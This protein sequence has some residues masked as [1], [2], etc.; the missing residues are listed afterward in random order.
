[1]VLIPE[2]CDFR[3]DMPICL[4]ACGSECTYFDFF[5]VDSVFFKA[6]V[7][8]SN[9]LNALRDLTL[10]TG[11]DLAD[12]PV[13]SKEALSLFLP[14]EDGRVTKCAAL[15][16]FRSA[17]VREMVAILKPESFNDLVKILGLVHSTGAWLDYGKELVTG[18]GL[19]LRDLIAD[20]DDVFDY[21][22]SMGIERAEAFAISDA[23]R[24]GM[25]A[26]K[27]NP[28]WDEWKQDMIR[29]GVPDWYL[30]LCQHINYLFPRAHSISYLIM[31]MRLAWFQ[32][33]CPEE[34]AFVM[35]ELD[36]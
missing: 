11:I 4:D 16:E 1:M 20:R 17:Y 28:K 36:L 34:F 32:L 19:S 21:L 9:A 31:N 27:R 35:S 14:D 30:S 10:R 24:K 12:V 26:R 13:C 15:P 5:F 29:A 22:I 18:K 7:L 25:I 3:K 23:V 6:D 33:H 8:T 2:G